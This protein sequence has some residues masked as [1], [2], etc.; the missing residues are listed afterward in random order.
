MPDESNDRDDEED[1]YK[2]I[3]RH[4]YPFCCNHYTL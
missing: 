3:R 2:D 4:Y 1:E